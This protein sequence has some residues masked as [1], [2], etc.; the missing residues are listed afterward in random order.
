MTRL[1]NAQERLD[2]ALT[3]LEDMAVRVSGSKTAAQVEGE[4]TA[5]RSRCDGLGARNREVSA[6]LAVAI[7]R[8]ESILEDGDGAG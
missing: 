2:R 3:Q 5:L 8:I 6:R 4:L 7:S 1:D